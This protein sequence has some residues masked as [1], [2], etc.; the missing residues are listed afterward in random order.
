MNE[1]F[2]SDFREAIL[3][4][5]SGPMKII[6]GRAIGVATSDKET[7][8]AA[9]IVDYSEQVAFSLV[10]YIISTMDKEKVLANWEEAVKDSHSKIASV[11]CYIIDNI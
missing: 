5:L 4:E 6:R 11:M 9:E 1:T 10:D 3:K 2:H 8:V 7:A